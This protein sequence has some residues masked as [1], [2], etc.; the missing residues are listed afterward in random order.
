[1]FFG[2][3]LVEN[4]VVTPEQLVEAITIQ[5]ESLPSIIR[6]VRKKNML[7]CNEIVDLVEKSIDERKNITELIVEKSIFAKDEVDG[8]LN[9]R[10]KG[11]MGLCEILV[12]E[13]LASSIM[14]SNYVKKY[15][16][17]QE[18]PPQNEEDD[19]KGILNFDVRGEFVRI[20]DEDF[21]DSINKGVESI[22]NKDREQHIFNIRK[23][24]SL[25]ATVAEMGDLEYVME[26]L[27][28]WL[29][30]LDKSEG[31]ADKGHWS[32]VA[33]GLKHVM[34][35]IWNLREEFVKNGNEK[36]PHGG[37]FVE[38]GIL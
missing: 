10:S 2:K 14:V 36:K 6:I 31:M 32:E 37:Q 26:L 18:N 15:L 11:G 16:E 17:G 8:L 29:E 7:D 5:M 27:Q 23:E 38:N 3:Y 21:L 35:L 33:S 1:M 30:V 9:E 25:L 12:R 34:K 19:G 20:F 22:R 28:I 13:G 24:L 4:G